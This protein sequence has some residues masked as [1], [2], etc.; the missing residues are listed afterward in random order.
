MKSH[1]ILKQY[2]CGALS[3][4]LTSSYLLEII[5]KGINPEAAKARYCLSFIERVKQYQAGEIS[6]D[7]LLLCLRD[8]VLYSGKTQVSKEIVDL[9]STRG[10]NYDLIREA[11]NIVT[12]VMRLP[13]WFKSDNFVNQV[14][15]LTATDEIVVEVSAG[16]K[17]LNTKTVFKNY[18]SFEQKAAIYSALKL[19]KG[20]TL[21]VSLPTG[22]GKS[23]ITQMLAAVD[24]GLT[25][26]VV[27]TVALA[28]DQNIAAMSSLS[29]DVKNNIFCYRGGQN[30]KDYINIINAL[31]N[32]TAR[33]LFTSPEAI[34]RNTTLFNTLQA[35]AKEKYLHNFVIDEAHIV[36]DWGTFFRPDF[37]ILSTVL[38]NWRI[39][40][41]NE[42]RTY[43][44][45][46]TLSDEVVTSLFKLYS[47]D[48]RYAE[49]RCDAFRREPR[50]CFY[51]AKTHIEQDN[52]V[53]ELVKTLPKP[54]VIYVYEPDEA[55]RTQGLLKEMG[56]KNIPIFT[57]KTKDDDRDEILKNWKA[58][59]YDI[60]VATSAFGIGVDKPDVRTIIHK[61]VPENLSRFYQEV[62]RGGRDGLPS[63]SVLVPY[64]GKNDGEGDLS[65]AFGLVNKRVLRVESI[66]I[67]WF[68]MFAKGELFGDV[69]IL[70][71]S[72]PPTTFSEHEVE[73][74]GDR[75]IAWNVNL[76]LFLYRTG[77]ID[78]QSVFYLA[79]TRSYHFKVKILNLEAMRD[80]V[81]FSASLESVRQKELDT[82]LEGYYLMKALVQKPE[83]HCWGAVF[84]KLYPLA[85]ER[86]NGCPQNQE[87]YAATESQFKIRTKPSIVLP[88]VESSKELKRYMGNYNRFVIRNPEKSEYNVADICL[89]AEKM[90]KA[91][92]ECIVLPDS[93]IGKIDYSGMIFTYDEFCFSAEYC[94]YLFAGG[95]MCVFD[96]DTIKNDMLFYRLEA[97]EE[98]GYKRVYYCDEN[99]YVRSQRRNISS[100]IDC[101]TKDAQNL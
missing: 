54:M 61:C 90:E 98:Y 80:D 45:S 43:L 11:D 41:G 3:K 56:F 31:K 35:C 76:L 16:E 70:N 71:T 34:L 26:V 69:A 30:E 81:S 53:L 23:L 93:L 8:I 82:Q 73:Y 14:Y 89:A 40:F 83:A 51:P 20:H 85:K 58:Q 24:D 88:P 60:V 75:N 42:I 72:T 64:V 99:M 32:K 50:F 74:A 84:K 1:E 2:L 100:F 39:Q 65:K 68:S 18:K 7:E 27:P 94:P 22:S 36:P 13:K 6:A 47:E 96:Y 15:S 55:K 48:D 57:G 46:A 21:L 44:L 87:V 33:L 49:F 25:L 97:F 5:K 79:E 91:R 92:V 66:V 37:Q 62:G 28:I 77:F 101:Y 29:D 67:R 78:I 38:M 86:C 52:M 95:V 63:L 19:P 4:D 12:A 59:K 10:K 9:V 17:L